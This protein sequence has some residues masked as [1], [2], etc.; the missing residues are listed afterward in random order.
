MR[1]KILFF[2]FWCYMLFNIVL[3]L[4]GCAQIFQNDILYLGN[5]CLFFCFI[6]F[7]KDIEKK[8]EG[9]ELP[10]WLIYISF[11]VVALLALAMSE[12]R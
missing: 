10:S 5:I 11:I 6:A 7:Y 1:N 3:Y 2:L 12:K 8:F 9:I 4:M